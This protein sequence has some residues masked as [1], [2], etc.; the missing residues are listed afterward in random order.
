LYA[1]FFSVL[2]LIFILSALP[3]C[4]KIGGVPVFDG[5][6]AYKYLV[7][8]CEIG[9]RVP[10]SP[11]HAK[12]QRYIVDRLNEFGAN[13]SLQPFDAVLTT[14]DTLHLVNIIGNYNLKAK[15]RILIGAHYD[16][17]P[18][19]D[20]DPNPANRNKPIPGANDGASGVAVMLE[21]AKIFKEH[22]PPVGVDILFI[23]GEDY[24]VDGVPQDY[25]LGSK[26]FA[27][28]LKGYKP[29][30]VII[31][32]MIGDADLSIGVEG[33]SSAASPRV[34]REIL[35]IAKGLDIK[36]FTDKPTPSLID[37]HLPFIQAGLNA[38]D[39]IDFDYPYWHTMQDTPD[40][41]SPQSL[42]DVGNVVLHFIWSKR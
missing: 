20:R 38:V 11:E 8:Q 29:F 42:E 19:A 32:D 39:L 2:F 35:D 37:D 27:S 9:P 33:L 25:I 22:K 30:V 40:K 17:R 21:M 31:L 26:Y 5:A 24:G 34:C 13:V 41:C 7:E 3:S 23:D 28:H 18:R 36:S 1:I 15:K 6:D 12:V 4:G 10:G 16:T 14:G